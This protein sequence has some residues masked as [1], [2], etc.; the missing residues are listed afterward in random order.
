MIGGSPD[1]DPSHGN[2]HVN[3]EANAAGEAVQHRIARE[4]PVHSQTDVSGAG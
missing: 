4:N 3:Q 1:E 2:H